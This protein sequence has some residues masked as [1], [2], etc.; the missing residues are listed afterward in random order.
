MGHFDIAHHIQIGGMELAKSS[1][2]ALFDCWPIF[3][4]EFLE[5]LLTICIVLGNKILEVLDELLCAVVLSSGFELHL[6]PDHIL[7]TAVEKQSLISLNFELLDSH[8]KASLNQVKSLLNKNIHELLELRALKASEP[9][10]DPINAKPVKLV[11]SV[12]EDFVLVEEK[13]SGFLSDRHWEV[14][15][16]WIYGIEVHAESALKLVPVATVEN[17]LAVRESILV[18]AGWELINF[19][20]HSVCWH[21]LLIFVPGPAHWTVP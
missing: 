2:L 10:I 5:F 9:I 11:G 20:H 1:V 18:F 3:L 21:H 16:H 8:V 15:I 13:N 17:R 7:I 4:E 6:A 12:I 19:C 14:V